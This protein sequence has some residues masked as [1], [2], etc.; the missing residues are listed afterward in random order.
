MFTQGRTIFCALLRLLP[1]VECWIKCRLLLL[2]FEVLVLVRV[3]VLWAHKRWREPSCEGCV[4]PSP[5]RHRRWAWGGSAVHE[6]TVNW[7]FPYKKASLT[8]Q[9]ALAHSAART[10][11]MERALLP[12]VKTFHYWNLFK[13][14][15]ITTSAESLQRFWCIWHRSE[16]VAQVVVLS[17]AFKWPVLWVPILQKAAARF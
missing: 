14:S 15:E 3:C 10:L 5:S 1:V 12:H 17:C 8:N 16:H 11:E 9:P 7:V 4:Q 2:T 13:C 6:A